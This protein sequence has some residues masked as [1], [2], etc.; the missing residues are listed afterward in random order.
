[1]PLIKAQCTNCNGLLQVDSSKDAAICPYCGTPYIVEKAINNFNATN[2]ITYQIQ[3]ASFTGGDSEYIRIKKLADYLIK[4]GD[5]V[6]AFHNYTLLFDRYRN[7]NPE[8]TV[9]M[10]KA[11]S[12]NYS[13]EHIKNKASSKADSF[14]WASD[15]RPYGATPADKSCYLMKEIDEI[16]SWLK[17]IPNGYNSAEY[18]NAV[19]FITKLIQAKTTIQQEWEDEENLKKKAIED[20]REKRHREIEKSYWNH[21]RDSALRLIIPVII[22]IIVGF[23]CTIGAGEDALCF[24][25][26][27][28]M[29]VVPFGI[30]L[31]GSN[32]FWW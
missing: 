9:L 21:K 12:Y 5:Y 27:L 10:I 13:V 1:M 26:F 28:L 20:E 19:S 15:D 18:Y 24:D 29:I 16:N 4:G 17:W 2:N 14:P 22:L 32:K 23:I 11:Y 8:N 6:Q 25:S 3:N 31:Y 30:W 7:I